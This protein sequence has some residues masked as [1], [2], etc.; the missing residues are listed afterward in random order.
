MSQQ[1][2]NEFDQ[3]IEIAPGVKY[4]GTEQLAQDKI[5]ARMRLLAMPP[6]EAQK[7]V[8]QTLYP[9]KWSIRLEDIKWSESISTNYGEDDDEAETNA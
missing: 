1:K 5:E 7:L 3:G 9:Q 8:E 4:G 6:A 2:D